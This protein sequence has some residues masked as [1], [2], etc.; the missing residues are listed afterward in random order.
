ML[1][2]SLVSTKQKDN[3]NL[4]N[5]TRRFRMGKEIFESHV[6]YPIILKKYILT[7]DENKKV[8]KEA[9]KNNTKINV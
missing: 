5:Y 1:L 6:G 8:K 3:E 4:Q 9:S 7:I 2:K